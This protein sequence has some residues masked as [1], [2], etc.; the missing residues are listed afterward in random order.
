M[1]MMVLLIQQQSQAELNRA[2]RSFLYD[3]DTVPIQDAAQGQYLQ[4]GG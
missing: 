3:A 1:A 2:F 4:R